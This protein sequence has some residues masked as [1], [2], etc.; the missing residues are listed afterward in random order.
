MRA[1]DYIRSELRK[2]AKYFRS[3]WLKTFSVDY[4]R[5]ELR[6]SFRVPPVGTLVLC[7]LIMGVFVVQ[8]KTGGRRWIQAYGA[9]P[10]SID[11]LSSLTKTGQE[12][13]VPAWLTLFTYM[14]RG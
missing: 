11:H 6:K 1:P 4:Q 7:C 5:S 10:A 12:Q 14:K 2:F 3:E 13:A 9:V 8:M